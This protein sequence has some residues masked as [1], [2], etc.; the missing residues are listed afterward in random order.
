M[1]KREK[2]YNKGFNTAYLFK[3]AQDKNPFVTEKN[4]TYFSSVMIWRH[5]ERSRMKE[6]SFC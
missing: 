1:L 5:I 4:Y 3:F 6:P 2:D